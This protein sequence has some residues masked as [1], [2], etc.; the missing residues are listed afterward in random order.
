MMTAPHISPRSTEA[1]L[2]EEGRESLKVLHYYLEEHTSRSERVG[3]VAISNHMLDAAKSVLLQSPRPAYAIH[4]LNP[5]S[6]PR[7]LTPHI[8]CCF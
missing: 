6:T 8:V 4:Q 3:F 2:P 5:S 7:L 1:G